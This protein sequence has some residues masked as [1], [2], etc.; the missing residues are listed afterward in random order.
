MDLEIINIDLIREL[1]HKAEDSERLRTA[2]D[3]RNSPDDTSQRMLNVLMPGT[4]VPTIGMKIPARP[5]FASMVDCQCY[6]MSSKMMAHL[7]K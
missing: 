1:I 7:Y 6:F 5:V 4:E 2:Y 3:L